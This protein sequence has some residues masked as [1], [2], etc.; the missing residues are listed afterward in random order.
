MLDIKTILVPVDF[1]HHSAK[2]LDYAIELAKLLGA[3]L[4]LLH[5]YPI[6]P[7]GIAPY[8]VMLPDGFERE[9]RQAASQHLDEW[10]QKVKDEGIEAE[11]SLTPL[12]PSRAIAESAIE[13]GAEMIVMGTHGHTGIKHALLGSVA[14]RTLR[15]APCPVL[16]VKSDDSD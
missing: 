11:I 9:V 1:S 16:T 10:A 14:E 3:K 6:N 7:G 5:C 13:I 4:H 2:S 8:G 15:M 12:F